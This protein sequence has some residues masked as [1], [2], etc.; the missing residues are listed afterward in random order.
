[1]RGR[2]LGTLG[3]GAYVVMPAGVLL[4]G[5]AVEW[6]GLG[7]ALLVVAIC[8]LAVTASLSVNR[9]LAE[10][11]ATGPTEHRTVSSVD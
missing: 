4:G 5:Y 1:M 10:M 7:R 3:A 11:D 8:Y 9:R 6:L 2:V